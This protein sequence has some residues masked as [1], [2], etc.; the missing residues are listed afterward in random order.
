MSL[1]ESK[2]SDEPSRFVIDQFLRPLEVVRVLLNRIA[3]EL[4]LPPSLKI[5]LVFHILLLELY[6]Y[7]AG[8][9]LELL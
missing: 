1:S 3:Y 2:G 8:T 9:T 5:Y 4:K 6:Y 7:Q